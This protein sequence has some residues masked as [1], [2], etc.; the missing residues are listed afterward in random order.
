MQRI[1]K[2]L[3]EKGF[4]K[5]RTAAQAA[6]MAGQIS[7]GDQVV[8]KASDSVDKQTEIN[9]KESAKYVSRGALKLKTAL[10]HFSIDVEGK[11]AL[12]AGASTGGFTQVLLEHGASK[13]IAVD[14]GYGQFDYNLRRDKRVKLLERTNIRYLDAES[15]ESV[16]IVVADLS[17]ISIT[18]VMD[19]IMTMT[20][21][22]AEFVILIK[23]QF[24]AE[25]RFAKKGV[26]RDKNVHKQ[27]LE[28]VLSQLEKKALFVAGLIPSP[29]KG[30]KGNI[31]FLAY[32]RRKSVKGLTIQEAIDFALEQV[33]GKTD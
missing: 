10:E 26:V 19:N 11:I 29:I 23:P 5:S 8:Q 4:F 33:Q 13:V 15:I 12:D 24:E 1:D 28:N 31:E 6:I 3:V 18:K 17:F 9:I 16:D 30:P 21:S 25:P 2:L 22:D 32:L 14:V 7:I 20:K 27:V